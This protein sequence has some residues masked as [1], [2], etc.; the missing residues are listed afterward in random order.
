MRNTSQKSC[1]KTKQRAR[2]YRRERV[3]GKGSSERGMAG[4]IKRA[5]ES[6]MASEGESRRGAGEGS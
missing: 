4:A 1:E 2:V 5:R 3:S 6:E